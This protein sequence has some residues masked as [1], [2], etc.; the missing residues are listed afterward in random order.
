MCSAYRDQWIGKLWNLGDR[1]GGDVL[2]CDFIDHRPIP[3]FPNNRDGHIKMALDWHS[4]FPDMIF[5]IEDIVVEDDK[6][7]ARYTAVGKHVARFLDLEPT[8]SQVRLTGI[9]MFKF[10]SGLMTEWWHN[11]DMLGFLAQVR[12]G[13]ATSGE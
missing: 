11:E 12:Q 9:D 1:T 13:K 6:L 7:V 2:S 3:Q 10:Q 8:Q 4:S 5:T